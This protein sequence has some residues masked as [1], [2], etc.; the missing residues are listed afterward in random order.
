MIGR[1]LAFVVGAAGAVAASQAPG[2]TLQYMQNLEGRV[3]ELRTVIDRFDAEIVRIG[4][5]RASALEECETAT[6]LLGV[7]CRGINAD[8]ARY[9]RLSA[10]QA[11]L[12]SAEDWVRPLVLA[13]SPERDVTESTLDQ[14][15]PALPVTPVG[16]G[17]AGGGFVLA[18]LAAS[19]V[20]GV[21]GAAFRPRRG[22]RGKIRLT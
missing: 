19:A 10:H 4:Y 13:R 6:R 9:E 5:D 1:L 14:F 17:Y 21:L 2:F 8:I 16:F 20:F 11:R 15:E 7:F 3:A 22:R 12:V 18:W